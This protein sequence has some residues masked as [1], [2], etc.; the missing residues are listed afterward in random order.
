MPSA[1]RTSSSSEANGICASDSIPRA[2]STLHP[3]GLIGSVIQQ[4]RLADPGLPNQRQGRADAVAGLRERDPDRVPLLL[5]PKQHGAILSP[6]T[7][8]R[9]TRCPPEASWDPCS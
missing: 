6:D 5:A 3:G 7:R 9:K 8:A 2:R 1:G 4:R